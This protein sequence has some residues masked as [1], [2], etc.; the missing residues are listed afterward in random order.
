M[1]PRRAYAAHEPLPDPFAPQLRGGPA[2]ISSSYLVYCLAR[3]VRQ[4]GIA[5]YP[6]IIAEGAVKK[7][8][9]NQLRVKWLTIVA[10]F[11]EKRACIKAVEPL[12]VTQ[13]P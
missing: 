1:R 13:H 6:T 9:M 2:A 10:P 11:L 4:P 7:N 8:N 5:S 3:L 12:S